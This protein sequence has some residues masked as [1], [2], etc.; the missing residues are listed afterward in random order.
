MWPNIDHADEDSAQGMVG[1]YSGRKLGPYMTVEQSCQPTW[2][3]YR[4]TIIWKRNTLFFKATLFWGLLL[5]YSRNLHPIW[6][7]FPEEDACDSS[8]T[9]LN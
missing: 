1:H 6:Y 5:F 9:L 3:T 2:M 7:C 8:L 4:R